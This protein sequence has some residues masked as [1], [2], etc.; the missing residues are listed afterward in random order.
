VRSPAF[1]EQST[2]V[3]ECIK[4]ES[5]LTWLSYQALYK[6]LQQ[7]LLYCGAA[8]IPCSCAAAMLGQF[9]LLCMVPHDC[10]AMEKLLELFFWA[11]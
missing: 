1:S 2:E 11:A 8:S 3:C 7:C 5:T 4:Q 10:Q 9:S 6:Q